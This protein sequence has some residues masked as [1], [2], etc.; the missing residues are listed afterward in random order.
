MSAKV[1]CELC[2]RECRL[3]EDQLGACRG[4][5]NVGGRIVCD[6]Y[7]E[8]TALNLDPIEKKPLARFHP[9]SMILSAGSYGCNLRCPFCQ[10]SSISMAGPGETHTTFVT[11]ESLVDA[12]LKTR[13]SGNIGIAFTYNEPFISYEYVRD[14]SRL[15]HEKGLLTVMVTNGMVNEQPLE[16]LLPLIDAMNIDL[17]GFTQGFYDRVGGNLQTVKR[18]IEVSATACHVEVTTLVIP[19]WN[20]GEDEMEEMSSWLAGIDPDLPYHI[21]RFFPC[22]RLNDVGPTPIRTIRSLVEVAR[23]HLTFVYRGNC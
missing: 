12:A 21:S 11:P 3:E 8:L 18:T 19:G 10:N 15:A 6:N 5:R 4:R 7:G 14:V 23:R 1:I 16:E 22:Y 13:S 2:P 9:G 20:D 17:K